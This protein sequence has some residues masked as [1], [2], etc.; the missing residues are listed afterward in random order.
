MV[1][2]LLLEYKICDLGENYYNF[3]LYIYVF[4]M[5]ILL[6]LIVCVGCLIL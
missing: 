4:L 5:Y 1:F 2:F 3:M 6:Y